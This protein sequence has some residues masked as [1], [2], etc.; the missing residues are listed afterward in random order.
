M[1]AT[2]LPEDPYLA[3]RLL[4]YFPQ[5]LRERF[6]DA[7]PRHP[8]AR[9][10]ITTVAINR[11]VNSQGSTAYHR[12]SS[13]TGAGIADVIRAQLAA[14]SIAIGRLRSPWAG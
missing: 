7:M 13:E 9:E 11:F 3:D 12:L 8:L 1:L 2:E 6:A 14:R 4:T 10:I 5:A